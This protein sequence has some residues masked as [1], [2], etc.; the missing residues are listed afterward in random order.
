MTHTKQNR[1]NFIKLS[2]TILDWEWYDHPPTKG[3]FIHLLLK[4]NYKDNRYRSH[5]VPA[6]SLVTSIPQLA[7]ETGLSV[8]QVRTALK[9]L[10]STNEI[11][12][13]TT[14][15]FTIISISKWYEYQTDN[16]PNNRPV[17]R[18]QQSCNRPIT[19]LKEGK[20]ERREE[21]KTIIPP[22]ISPPED[23]EK[24]IWEDFYRLRTEK[25]ALL[26]P[27]ALDGIRREANKA[28]WSLNDALTECCARGWIGFKAEWVKKSENE[29]GVNGE[30]FK[31]IGHGYRQSQPSYFD[32]LAAAARYSQARQMEKE[33]GHGYE[34]YP[35]L[36]IPT[37]FGTGEDNS[38]LLHIPSIEERDPATSIETGD[39]QTFDRG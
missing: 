36:V 26:S 16:R 30:K 29:K 11:T 23:V 5:D 14:R 38:D 7:K 24:N 35:D 12:G 25:K 39:A 22:L 32:K 18:G 1:I 4:A 37:P 9:N 31:H 27:T 8:M 19:T 34:L 13:T 21:G 6:G 2:R 3:V 10:K 20:K 28:G 17:T 33:R 15:N